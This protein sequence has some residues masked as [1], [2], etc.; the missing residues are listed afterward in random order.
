MRGIPGPAI[1]AALLITLSS[2]LFAAANT[3]V[4]DAT[5]TS[6]WPALQVKR[7]AFQV[8]ILGQAVTSDNV[9]Q[10]GPSAE[11]DATYDYTFDYEDVSQPVAGTDSAAIA[12]PACTTINQSIQSGYPF[13]FYLTS[14]MAQV[15]L[16]LRTLRYSTSPTVVQ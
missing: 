11:D 7:T 8:D 2:P 9:T 13:F 3:Y 10:S 15:R 6:S 14:A 12:D 1:L 16:V 4:L 5:D